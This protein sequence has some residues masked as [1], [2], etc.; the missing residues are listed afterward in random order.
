MSVSE[1]MQFVLTAN[2]D[3]YIN[4]MRK[5]GDATDT[6]LGKAES[7]LDSVA[8]KM[9]KFGVGAVAAAGVAAVG[10]FKVGQSAS[11]LG[12]SVN[13]VNVTFGEAAAGVLK[14]GENA[15]KTVGLS[16]TEFNGLAVQF[17][18]FAETI[19]GKGG[20]VVGTLDNLT[21]R[22]ADFASVMNLEVNDA[23]ALFQ[24]GLAGE[25]EPLRKFGLDLSA[26]AVDAYAYAHGIAE[27]GKQLTEGEKV[28]ARYG[29]LMEKTAKNAGDFANTSD[30]LANQQRILTAE[31]KNL[32]SGIGQGVLPVMTTMISTVRQGVQMFTDLPAPVQKTIGTFATLG[33]GALAAAGSLSFTIGKVISMRDNLSQLGPKASGA[34]VVLGVAATATA[35][36]MNKL[37]QEAQR[38]VDDFKAISRASDDEAIGR[39]RMELFLTGV[40]GKSTSETLKKFAEVNIE[41]AKRVR[42][43]TQARIDSGVATQQEIGLVAGLQAAIENEMTAR[44]QEAVTARESSDAVTQLSKDKRDDKDATTSVATA[45]RALSKDRRDD[46]AD[47]KAQAAATK[48]VE[49]SLAKMDTALQTLKGHLDER[50][51]W[52]NVLQ[53]MGAMLTLVA[54][55]TAS[56]RD[57]GAATDD[58]VSKVADYISAIDNIKPEVKTYLYQELDKGNLDYVLKVL[59]DLKQGVDV[60]VYLKTIGKFDL[61]GARAG[62]GPVNDGTYLVGEQGPELLSIGGSGHVTP[63]GET[64]RMLGGGAPGWTSPAPIVVNVDARGAIGLSPVDLQRVVVTAIERYKRKGGTL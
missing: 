30:G 52:E 54:S 44:A 51:A 38:T 28:Q 50:S 25:S 6:E 7:K 43:L 47:A 18:S 11:D 16:K 29:L 32:A 60:P 40:E 39:F 3:G 10:L 22:A 56:W 8:G 57:L 24:S 37:H 63:A 19:A 55:G 62:G 45:T 12:E 49:D 53:S 36:Y 64:A 2:A 17:S 1:K 34:L 23:T 4:A 42:D 46:A 20:D 33:V 26:A 48:E 59:E 35:L 5:A 21:Q 41:G 15:A 61:K 9:T 13:A 31:L 14:L 58:E 27:T